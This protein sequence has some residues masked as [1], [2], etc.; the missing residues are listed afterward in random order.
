MLAQVA[1]GTLLTREKS[2]GSV[3][4]APAEPDGVNESAAPVRVASAAA[5]ALLRGLL[6]RAPAARYGL[7]DLV[8]N[9]FITAGG[10]EERS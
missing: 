7:A 10:S 1:A 4:Q 8:A 3:G 9:D 2:R 5:S 6:R